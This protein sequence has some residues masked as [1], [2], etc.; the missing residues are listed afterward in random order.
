MIIHGAGPWGHGLD[1]LVLAGNL[2]DISFPVNI[3][4][5]DGATQSE[6]ETL[7]SQ[8]SSLA[9]YEVFVLHVTAD[10]VWSFFSYFIFTDLIFI[11]IYE[12][13]QREPIFAAAKNLGLLEA[14]YAWLGTEDIATSTANETA[15]TVN[16]ME[17]VIAVRPK[18]PNTWESNRLRDNITN[19]GLNMI[20]YAYYS[21]DAV[22]T[23]AH[24]LTYLID[25]GED[26]TLHEALDEKDYFS[27]ITMRSVDGDMLGETITNLQLP[28]TWMMSGALYMSSNTRKTSYE[29]INFVNGDIAI[30]GD[31][32]WNRGE[33]NDYFEGLLESLSVTSRNTSGADVCISLD[34]TARASNKTQWNQVDKLFY[35]QNK[36][37]TYD[38]IEQYQANEDVIRFW[39]Q[40]LRPILGLDRVYSLSEAS[41]DFSMM[42]WS[43]SASDNTVIFSGNSSDIPL[44]AL[45][46]ASEP[47]RVLAWLVE[48]WGDIRTIDNQTDLTGYFGEVMVTGFLPT[49]WQNMTD[50]LGITSEYYYEDGLSAE[51]A[52]A[53]IADGKYDVALGA[54]T[55]TESRS[56]I[57]NFIQQFH[58]GG[59]KI[60]S[61]R[62]DS[63]S[64]SWMFLRPFGFS[65][66]FA[67]FLTIIFVAGWI[68]I[69]EWDTD[70][71]EDEKTGEKLSFMASFVESVTI[72]SSVLF[73]TH[74]PPKGIHTRVFVLVFQYIIL[75]WIA[76]YTA[77]M[78][79]FLTKSSDPEPEV[80]EFIHLYHEDTR[81]ATVRDG[82]SE[83]VMNTKSVDIWKLCNTTDECL[84]F[85]YDSPDNDTENV[86][87]YD[88]DNIDYWAQTSQSCS[89]VAPGDSF[90]SVS[91]AF[92][93]TYNVIPDAILSEL[94]IEMINLWSTGDIQIWIEQYIDI[95]YTCDAYELS[96]G[97][98][99][100]SIS[101][102]N[103][104]ELFIFI[105]AFSLCFCCFLVSQPKAEAFYKSAMEQR[106][107]R[108]KQDMNQIKDSDD[109]RHMD[110]LLNKQEQIN[111]GDGNATNTTNTT[112]TQD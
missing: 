95:L 80:T 3:V 7:L 23:V 54:F 105:G 88:D 5:P 97:S 103:M 24:A 20:Y 82:Y 18:T 101:I 109:H 31:F 70:T 43:F 37:L 77:N 68:Y 104:A 111:D 91:F 49:I 75:V 107:I 16:Y 83:Q 81:V 48:P 110:E 63:V 78:A 94:N 59:L 47:L 21:Y 90:N 2:V 112:T 25:Q 53:L 9:A 50:N 69:L 74:E 98:D 1:T 36:A 79:S 26:V 62:P 99:T 46:K 13:I 30:V 42:E 85:V 76:A 41:D 27:N 58:G 12:Y 72:S 93:T 96:E 6:I 39:E 89:L 38:Y 40:C 52:I 73:Y 29:L 64:N 33:V 60:L 4:I 10:L 17:G 61:K 100:E 108:R 35:V 92:P 67:S 65:L 56:S 55:V 15:T 28:P 11:S 22:L 71:F 34:W 44:G 102:E 45:W 8:D 14:G 84:E 51:E 87:V 86:F 66:W 57:V 32:K 19:S 106:E